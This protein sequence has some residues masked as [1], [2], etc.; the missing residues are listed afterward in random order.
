MPERIETVVIGGSQAGLS[1][2]Y[3]L[4]QRGCEHLVLEQAAKVAEAWRSGRWDSFT[5]VTPNWAFR[6]PGAEYQ[7]PAP[8]GFMPRDEIVATIERYAE[9]FRLPVRHGVRVTSVEPLAGG[10][11]YLVRADGAAWEARNVV[12]ATGMFQQP[13]LPPCSADIP[14]R[15]A[16]LHTGQ[17]RN[18]RA[19]PDGA[20]L[21]VGSAQSGCQIAEELYQSG[22]RVYLSLGSAG[23]IPRRYRGKDI[24]D[25]LH[26]SGFFDWTVDKLP[27]P[28][29]RFGGNPHLTGRDGGHTISLH[30]FAREGVVLLGHLEGARGSKVFLATD[31]KERLAKADKFEAE[32]LKMID[33]AIERKGL[34]AGPD[35]VPQLRDGYEAEEITELD[36]DSAGITTIIWGTGYKFDFSLIRAPVFERNGFPVQ[37]SGVTSQ[38]GLYFAGL[39]WSDTRKTGLLLG[40]GKQ[41]E[42]I[43]STIAS[44]GR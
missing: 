15:I 44:A 17:Y 22:R 23:R 21:V 43:A 20:I 36:L 32:I 19:L 39:G 7:G 16:Q 4:S 10:G 42:H 5:L 6:L 29:A 37:R 1:T 9:R 25:W 35:H 3:H 33:D 28:E 31:V 8:D 24:V 26:L 14:P 27:S 12:V 30:Q 13:K 34:E 38:P 41:A 40:V 18:P 2:S 11:G